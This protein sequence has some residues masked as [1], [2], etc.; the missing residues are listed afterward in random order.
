M[1]FEPGGGLPGAGGR[2]CAAV[3]LALPCPTA[4][5]GR[6]FGHAT[7]PAGPDTP[8]GPPDSGTEAG[9]PGRLKAD[10]TIASSG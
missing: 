5:P 6:S 9:G 10:G 3:E 8:L 1:G 7:W 4:S 2:V